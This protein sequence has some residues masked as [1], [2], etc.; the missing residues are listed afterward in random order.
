MSI[1]IAC[2]VGIAGVSCTQNQKESKTQEQEFKYL[3][4]EFADLKVIRYKVPGWDDLTLQQK[5]FI[6][7]M[8]EAAKCGRDIFWDQN[9]KHNLEVRRALENVLESYTGDR[10]TPEF[11]EFLVYAKRVFFSNG[12][13]HHYAEEKILPGCNAEYM[14]HLLEN[15]QDIADVDKMVDI[16]CDPGLYKTRKSAGD[17]G[18]LL[19]TSATNFYSGVTR[20]EAEAF[21]GSLE[22]TEDPRPVEYG[23]N[24][25]L[26][27]KDGKIFE[28]VYAT[29]GLYGP[30][31]QQICHWLEKAAE[32]AESPE[33]SSYLKTLIN[34]YQ[35]GDLAL[36]DA[37]NVAWVQDTDT[38]LDF[39]NGFVEVYGDPLGRKG[40]WEGN[41]NYIDKEASRRTAIISGNA[42]W[43]EDHSP[44]D[45]RFKKENVTGVSAKVINV[46]MLGGDAFPSTPIGINLPNSDWI[47]KE[48]GSKSV[49]IANITNAYEKAAEESP[50]NMLDEFSWNEEEIALL[51]KYGTLT[52][53]LHTDLHE[54]LGH[55][56]GQLLP[57]VS[58]NALQ[59]YSSTLE[60][61]RADLFALYY[62][63]D[64][65]LVELGILPDTTAYKAE[66]INYIRNGLFTQL[67]RI[68]PGKDIT[69]AHMQCRQLIASW[70]LKNGNAIER[71]VKDGKSYFVVNDY[72][73]LRKLFATLLAEM[74][75][76]KSEGDYTAGKAMV[77]KYAVK[78]D[79]ELHKEVLERYA[80][81]NLKP[82]GGFLNPNIIPVYDKKGRLKD[83]ELE[84]AGGFLEQHLSYG[85]AYGFL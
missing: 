47:R 12:I 29:E 62:L 33:Q 36:W 69:Q 60:E 32:V 58:S 42:Q 22:E 15:S 13:H 73:G 2:L 17:A 53:N 16:M 57:G 51:K 21:Y 44:I 14:R 81:L 65:K 27:K 45:P 68:E 7:Y 50:K 26:V 82:Y 46:A 38:E 80:S 37:F 84:Y 30:A 67:V 9:F 41:V 83:L 34:Y 75:R 19:M 79:Q 20:A 3:V 77:E 18:D 28:E 59:D 52:G 6:Y 63:G 64:P 8:G 31:L 55:G 40:S 66:Y 49:T 56:S 4:D 61:V 35:T 76:I 1:A 85:R 54:C 71:K 70:C 78:V 24:S 74:Q 72:Q 5:S 11:K 25:R 43:F 23:L 39:V 10:E 48:Y